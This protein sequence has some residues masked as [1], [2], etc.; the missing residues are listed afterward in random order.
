[1]LWKHSWRYKERGK[2]DKTLLKSHSNTF[3]KVKKREKM[4]CVKKGKIN[5]YHLSIIIFPFDSS[6]LGI[7]VIL[8][9]F[10]AKTICAELLF[11]G[12][13]KK[14]LPRLENIKKTQLF[15]EKI[16]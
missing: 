10:S 13:F 3:I 5:I 2:S 4:A 14:C 6:V 8:Y 9:I 15:N 11:Y 1:M 16:A 7:V 12:N